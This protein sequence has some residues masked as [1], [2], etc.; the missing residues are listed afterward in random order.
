MYLECIMSLVMRITSGSALEM[1][2]RVFVL[3]CTWPV[4]CFAGHVLVFVL[5]EHFCLVF[6]CSHVFCLDPAH[7]VT[8]LLVQLPHLLSLIT[9]L[10]CSVY[11]PCVCSPVSSLSYVLCL[12][13]DPALPFPAQHV[14]LPAEFFPHGV[15]F[16]VVLVLFLLIKYHLLQ[17]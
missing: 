1:L 16:V 2:I 8:S 5:C 13:P 11:F 14:K 10:I 17:Y 7:L 12:C 6:K 15:V 3:F 9:L 4:I